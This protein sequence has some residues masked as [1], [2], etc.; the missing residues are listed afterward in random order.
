MFIGVYLFFGLND[1]NNM[2]SLS[3]RR[4]EISC[5][6]ENRETVS[7]LNKDQFRYLFSE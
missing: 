1:N 4:I 3:P 6:M 7:C 5:N 2:V